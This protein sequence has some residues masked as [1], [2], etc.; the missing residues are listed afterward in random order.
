MFTPRRH[1]IQPLG[2]CPSSLA[3]YSHIVDESKRIEHV[4]SKDGVCP[5]LDFVFILEYAR[6]ITIRY[7]HFSIIV[8][9]IGETGLNSIVNIY[10]L[11]C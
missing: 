2:L 1:L 8:C 10:S 4:A 7:L 9:A 6:L 5:A 3:K 11:G